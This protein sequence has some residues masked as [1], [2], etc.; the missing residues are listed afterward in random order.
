MDG[1]RKY[2][3]ESGN[4]I[5]KEYTWYALTDKWILVKKLRIPMIKFTD[6]M[7]LKM[8]KGQSVDTLVLLR[9]GRKYPWM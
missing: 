5:T 8:R 1:T 9:T 7:K 2:Q 4:P 3:P 6:H